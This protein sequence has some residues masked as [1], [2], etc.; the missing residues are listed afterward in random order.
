MK[1]RIIIILGLEKK[2]VLIADLSQ[3]EFVWYFTDVSKIIL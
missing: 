3:T 1:N 2:I